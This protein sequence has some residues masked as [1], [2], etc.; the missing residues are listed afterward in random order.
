MSDRMD[1]REFL[2]LSKGEFGGTRYPMTKDMNMV[3]LVARIGESGRRLTKALLES[4]LAEDPRNNPA[5][6][7]CRQCQGKLRIQES[8]QRRVISTAIG[9]IEYRRAY[10]VCDRCGHTGA[11]LDEALGIPPFGP[12]ME[13]RQ[14]ICHAAATARSFEGASEILEEQ[15]GIELSA[16]QV[17]V[18]SETEGKTLAEER[19]QEVASLRGGKLIAGPEKPPDL[20]VVTADGGRIQT[21]QVD[22]DEKGGVWK[23]DKVGAIYEASP[24]KDP[25]A[26]DAEKYEGAKAQM[27]TFAASLTDWDEFGWMLCVEALKRGYAK[28]KEKLFISDGAQSLRTL[29]QDHFHDATF[30]LDWYHAVEHLSDCAK[31][32]FGENTEECARWYKRMK[33]KLW[34]GDLD[35]VIRSVEKES[36]RKGKPQPKEHEGSPRVILHRNIGYFSDNREGMDYPRFRA[37]GWPIG[38]GV[39]EGAVKQFGMRLKGSEKFWNGFG[40]G[41]GAEEMLALCALHRSEDGRWK[42]H[43]RRRARPCVPLPHK[44]DAS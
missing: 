10:G 18:V 15:A 40:L 38:S 25:E 2:G 34:M 39:A 41:M 32:A 23:E 44:Q 31:S 35:G 12:S 5:D 7:V 22:E 28:A 20:I 11:P 16:K 19:A 42:E 6:P 30:I 9:E 1:E 36:V 13:T 24:R 43:W 4:R 3:E 17:R 27:K 14:K 37:E 8:A 21:R 33:T 29:R 26:R